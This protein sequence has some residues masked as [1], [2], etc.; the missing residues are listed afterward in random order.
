LVCGVEH[1]RSSANTGIEAA[2]GKALERKPTNSCVEPAGCEAKKRGLPLCRV[3]SGI[4]S[5][6]RWTDR[7]HCRQQAEAN[8]RDEKYWNY[9]F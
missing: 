9:V 6:R 5:V 3:A 4:A 2:G 7:L 8:Q 1:K